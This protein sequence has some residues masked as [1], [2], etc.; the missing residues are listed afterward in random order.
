MTATVDPDKLYIRAEELERVGHDLLVAHDLPPEDATTV[1]RCL[2]E[3]DLR[4]VET[5]GVVRLP[6]YLNRVRLGLI[7]P[8]PDIRIIRATPVAISMTAM[9]GSASSSRTGR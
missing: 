7:K 6:H 4:G 1:A 3:A 8:R 2:V 9:T 5:H